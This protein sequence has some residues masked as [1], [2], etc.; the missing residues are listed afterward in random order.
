MEGIKKL[1]KIVIEIKDGKRAVTINGEPLDLNY[2]LSMD[3]SFEGDTVAVKTTE[4]N[5]YGW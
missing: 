3:I 5:Y 1:E 2:I 4:K